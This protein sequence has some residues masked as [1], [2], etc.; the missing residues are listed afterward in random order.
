MRRAGQKTFILGFFACVNTLPMPLIDQPVV[1][2][3][4]F[5]LDAC[6]AGL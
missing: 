6:G 1:C 2:S 4:H 3:D 5:I